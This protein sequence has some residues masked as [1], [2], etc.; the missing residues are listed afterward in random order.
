MSQ[1][2]SSTLPSI[3]HNDHLQALQHT[4]QKRNT[5]THHT[6]SSRHAIRD[7]YRKTHEDLGSKAFTSLTNSL[8]RAFTN[9]VKVD[10]QTGEE[11][12]TQGGLQRVAKD[13][14]KLFK[15]MGFP[16]QMAKQ[17]ARDISSAMGQEGVEQIDFSLETTRS[18]TVSAY[19]QS[20]AGVPG[21]DESA[22]ASSQASGLQLTVVQTRN[23]DVS[24]NL[25]TGEFSLTRT[26]DESLTLSTVAADSQEN[27][28]MPTGLNAEDTEVTPDEINTPATVG[29]DTDKT[30]IEEL[31]TV[32]DQNQ[33]DAIL[34]QLSHSI[35]QSTLFTQ[36]QY[37]DETGKEVTD[38]EQAVAA[39]NTLY[40]LQLFAETRLQI[41][42]GETSL[43]E[44]M[45]N[46]SNLRIESIDQQEYLRFS[47]QAVA[48][49][50]LTTVDK[51]G[52][53]STVYPRPN[54][55]I[56]EMTT[57]SQAVSA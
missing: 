42:F 55:G 45:T 20:G 9:A 26:Y 47:V 27:T 8:A 24:I 31:P 22:V 43:F 12:T 35:S 53:S 33:V 39:D 5:P 28:E 15:G 25:T 34:F 32:T 21:D 1:N 37:A 40:Q 46:I 50:G 51:D 3:N 48:P 6:D 19:N 52:S 4:H 10:Q 14:Q 41:N 2:I 57:E 56:G 17:Y 23:F 16:P 11:E 49:V 30:V 44:S 18:L 36:Q 54:G 13:L 7:R 38:G 29:E